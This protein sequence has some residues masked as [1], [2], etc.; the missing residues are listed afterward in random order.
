MDF[1][2]VDILKGPES[3]TVT[4]ELL[5]GSMERRGYA[6]PYGDGWEDKDEDGEFKF[7]KNIKSRVE[8][9]ERKKQIAISSFS[10]MDKLRGKP[11]KREK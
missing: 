11:F 10:D 3:F 6:F 4:I 1:K 7:V 9:M 5:D 8:D 2:I